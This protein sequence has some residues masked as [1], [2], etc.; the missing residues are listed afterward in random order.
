MKKERTGMEGDRE[1]KVEAVRLAKEI[2][3]AR[4]AKELGVP[5]NTLCGWMQSSRMGNLDLGSGAQSPL[6]R[7]V[8]RLEKE[9]EFWRKPALFRC[10]PSEVSKNER[11][12]F[13]AF[14]TK[15]GEITGETARTKTV[16]AVLCADGRNIHSFVICFI[17]RKGEI[18]LNSWRSL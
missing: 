14:K 4:A 10:D 16:R 12:K 9:N 6:R 13:I 3:Q 17:Q 2:G 15:D 8:K 7:E 5:K 11:M 1:Y 18:N